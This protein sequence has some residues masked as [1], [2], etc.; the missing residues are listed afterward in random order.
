MANTVTLTAEQVVL[1]SQLWGAS[2]AL[3]RPLVETGRV[4]RPLVLAGVV[5]AEPRWD[6]ENKKG[7]GIY[8]LTAFGRQTVG[9][10]LSGSSRVLHV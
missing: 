6:E 8:E 10:V 9:P 2:G 7:V 4:L 3:R 1:L 5:H